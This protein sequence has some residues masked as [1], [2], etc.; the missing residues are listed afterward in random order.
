MISGDGKGLRQLTDG[1]DGSTSVTPI[2]S[3]D[4]SKLLFQRK[5]RDEVTL[6]TMNADGTRQTQVTPTPVAVDFV[7]GYAW[8]PFPAQ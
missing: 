2:W 4:G 6:W 8:A 3:P 1:T 5:Q 7:G